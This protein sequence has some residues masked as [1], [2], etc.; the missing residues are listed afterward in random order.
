MVTSERVTTTLYRHC[1]QIDPQFL[2][3]NYCPSLWNED[4]LYEQIQG[5]VLERTFFYCKWFVGKL[6]GYCAK[7]IC[8]YYSGITENIDGSST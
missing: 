6:L 4:V 2:R 7:G 8:S 1:K 5:D 3:P